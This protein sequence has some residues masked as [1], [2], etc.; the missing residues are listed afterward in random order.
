MPKPK[1]E[2]KP[3]SK[4]KFTKK[5]KSQQVNQHVKSIPSTPPPTPMAIHN[6]SNG[7]DY[8]DQNYATFKTSPMAS[9]AGIAEA[10]SGA[11]TNQRITR[12]QIG[13][14][15]K[16]LTIVLLA[17]GCSA[18]I[19]FTLLFDLDKD[20]VKHKPGPCRIM[21]NFSQFDGLEN[22]YMEYVEELRTLFITEEAQNNFGGIYAFHPPHD[23]PQ[24]ENKQT[25]WPDKPSAVRLKIENSETSSFDQTKFSPLGISVSVH[26]SRAI[27]YVVNTFGNE[28]GGRAIEVFKYLPKKEALLHLKTI[29]D[30]NFQSIRDVQVVAGG[31][32]RFFVV[33]GFYYQNKL[34]RGLEIITQ[35]RS[36]N[37]VFYDGKRSKIVDRS[38]ALPSAI[39]LDKE[40]EYIYVSNYMTETIKS[41]HLSKDNSLSHLAEIGLLSSPKQIYV[42]KKTGDLWVAAQP[43]FHKSIKHAIWNNQTR[44]PSH[45]LRIRFQDTRTSWVTTEPFANDGTSFSGITGITLIGEHLVI[46]SSTGKHYVCE[47]INYKIA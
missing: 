4:F 9:V 34:L 24:S 39:T 12:M 3:K 20:V 23:Q 41:Y 14:I 8:E 27:L 17:F 40:R 5:A 44:V 30:D 35:S 10:K 36:G 32:D 38:L 42:E 1:L 6:T 11:N 25:H 16:I 43:V 47:I 37:L 45:V 21:R 13:L 33:N 46:G 29:L 18:I 7:E 28:F 22:G 26:G 2:P 19:R 15:Q 31:G